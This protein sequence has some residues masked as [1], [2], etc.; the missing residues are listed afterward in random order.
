MRRISRFLPSF[1]IAVND[2]DLVIIIYSPRERIPIGFELLPERFTMSSLRLIYE[3][4][5]GEKLDRRN[6]QRKILSTGLIVKLEEKSKKKGVKSASLFCF[7][8]ENYKTAEKK[9][10]SFWR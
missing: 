3:A 6:F 4:I 10:M 9:G 1:T 5:I 8:A 2:V 7:D